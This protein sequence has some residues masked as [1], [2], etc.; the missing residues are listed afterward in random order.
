[1]TVNFAE[2]FD[3]LDAEHPYDNGF[4]LDDVNRVE[5]VYKEDDVITLCLI[6]DSYGDSLIVGFTNLNFKSVEDPDR[7][8]NYG[9]WVF[10]KSN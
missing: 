5:I 2:E 9:D 6:N 7:W 8:S 3:R 10:N 1:M 4:T